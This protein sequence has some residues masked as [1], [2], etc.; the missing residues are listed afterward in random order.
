VNIFKRKENKERWK[1]MQIA[2]EK[3]K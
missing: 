3:G 1:E 2:K